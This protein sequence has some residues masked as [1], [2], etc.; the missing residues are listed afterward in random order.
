M[1]Q[2]CDWD[3]RVCWCQLHQVLLVEEDFT[4]IVG[5]LPSPTNLPI[6]RGEVHAWRQLFEDAG[7]DAVHD[8]VI[9]I[10]EIAGNGKSYELDRERNHGITLN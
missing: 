4:A 6:V 3:Y 7:L 10:P 5:H 1:L 9:Q 2:S 8:L